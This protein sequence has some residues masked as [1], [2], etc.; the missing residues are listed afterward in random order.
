MYRLVEEGDKVA[1]ALSGG[2]DSITVLHLLDKFNVTHGNDIEL[3]AI[4]I[5]QGIRGVDEISLRNSKEITEARGIEH[6]VVSLKEEIGYTV[7]ELATMRPGVCNCGVFRRNILNRRAREL[8]AKKLATG[9][10]LDDEV[11][12]ALMNFIT[13]NIMRMVRGDGVVNMSKFVRRIKPL[14][15]SP[16]EEVA[17]YASFVFPGLEFAPE[18]PYRGQVIRRNV[19]RIVD[20]LENHHPG[21]RYQ[22]L[23]SSE[24]LREV[25]LKH[26]DTLAEIKECS[27]CG[28]PTSADTCNMCELLA[29]VGQNAE[30]R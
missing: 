5:D 10:N 30:A 14:R 1:V 18:C 4:T 17:L 13:G 12:S 19:K 28:E 15:R 21:I 24:G 8:G 29:R 23:E 11:E 7:D 27:I 26:V 16:E 25:L 22:V 2:K 20:D 3:I 6:H 9:H